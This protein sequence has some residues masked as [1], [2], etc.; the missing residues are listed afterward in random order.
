MEDYV[1]KPIFNIRIYGILEHEDSILISDELHFGRSIS[2]FPG[3]GLQFGEGTHECLVREFEEELNIGI[4]I[5]DHFYTTDF[6]QPSAFD[7]KQQVVSIYYRI[8]SP[9]STKI[10]TT[11]DVFNFK[12]EEGITQQFRW[13]KKQLLSPDDLTFPIDKKVA[14]MIAQRIRA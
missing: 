7:P 10:A 1:Y 11:T 14:T 12:P 13:I 5:T 3:G 6:F 8:T 2:K 9:E 4:K